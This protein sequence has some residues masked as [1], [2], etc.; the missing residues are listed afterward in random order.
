MA[1]H[2]GLGFWLRSLI[3]GRFVAHPGVRLYGEAGSPRP[4]SAAELKALERRIGGARWFKG[5]R[6]IWSGLTTVRD[7]RITGVA[8]VRYPR[9]M[10]HLP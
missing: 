10:E 9:M 2:S 5:S 6:L 8:P 7:I 4:A 1:V 3:Q